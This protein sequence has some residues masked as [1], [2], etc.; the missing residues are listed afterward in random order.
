MAKLRPVKDR[1]DR[2]T[3]PL[4]DVLDA[5]LQADGFELYGWA[6]IKTTGRSGPTVYK[7]LERL[8]EMGW[9][10]ARWDD[11]PAEPN[12][13]RRRYYTLTGDAAIPARRLLTER[14]P[15]RTATPG[16]PALG[17]GMT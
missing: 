6:I 12:R 5:F 10:S 16:R 14:R 3:P 15:A 9:V 2:V 4:L 8:T 1:P 11:Q 13:P 7:I 17:G